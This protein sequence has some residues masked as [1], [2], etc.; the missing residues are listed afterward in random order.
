MDFIE[1]SLRE[2]EPELS[3]MG[4]MF[5]REI[6]LGKQTFI[7][8]YENSYA[9]KRLQLVMELYSNNAFCKKIYK[10]DLI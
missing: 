5:T 2:I 1:K 6:K 3:A 4:Y 10:E 7:S 9:G 8:E